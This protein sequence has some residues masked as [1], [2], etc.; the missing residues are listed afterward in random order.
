MERVHVVAYDG[1]VDTVVA[2]VV[3][4][5][6]L[7]ACTNASDR[8]HYSRG[9]RVHREP[10]P[11]PIHSR[12]PNHIVC[13]D[14]R[15]QWSVGRTIL[16]CLLPKLTGL[17]LPRPGGGVLASVLCAI[18]WRIFGHIVVN[19]NLES[20]CTGHMTHDG[21]SGGLTNERRRCK[22]LSGGFALYRALAPIPTVCGGLL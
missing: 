15:Q 11:P 10:P 5:V 14:P 21:M 7:R 19:V 8:E 1:T 22:A 2:V 16:I 9:A 17:A 4:A 18:R 3:V 20:R 12:G 6:V 13:S